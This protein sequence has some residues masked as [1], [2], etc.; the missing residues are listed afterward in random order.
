MFAGP[1]SECAG[2]SSAA[3]RSGCQPS[4]DFAEQHPGRT[5]QK[6]GPAVQK[7]SAPRPEEPSEPDAEPDS[8]GA[9][10]TPEDE[11][12]Q[13]EGVLP[14]P[15][16]HRSVRRLKRSF[17]PSSMS[18]LGGGATAVAQAAAAAAAAAT[19]NDGRPWWERLHTPARK[20]LGPQLRQTMHSVLAAPRIPPA[21]RPRPPSAPLSQRPVP[22]ARTPVGSAA[23]VAAARR[24]GA[25][26]EAQAGRTA[27]PA[28]S[29]GGGLRPGS[30]R[31]SAQR[32]SPDDELL[33]ED[34]FIFN[35]DDADAGAGFFG[36]DSDDDGGTPEAKFAA[37]QAAAEAA[38]AKGRP[39]SA[40]G[41]GALLLEGWAR[42]TLAGLR[43]E[44]WMRETL[45]GLRAEASPQHPSW[46]RCGAAG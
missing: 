12:Q 16:R 19:A 6:V 39:L 30:G 1:A 10:S 20:C 14:P 5:F 11:G 44:E 15:Q 40:P 23:A 43:A 36:V 2:P 32:R 41:V 13:P 34:S 31:T 21:Q 33:R 25:S 28:A 24:A 46:G 35:D 4:E 42:D 27:S 18:A 8:A 29:P 3:R 9:D 26:A 37:K 22:A 38:R 7:V 17:T 45:S